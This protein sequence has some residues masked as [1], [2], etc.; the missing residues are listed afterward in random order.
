M[1]RQKKNAS[2]YFCFSS[3]KKLKLEIESIDHNINDLSVNLPAPS[4]HFST[5]VSRGGGKLNGSVSRLIGLHCPVV[6]SRLLFLIGNEVVIKYLDPL[7]ITLFRANL[8][9]RYDM[10]TRQ[11]L[12]KIKS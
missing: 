4:V 1:I 8:I 7:W 11:S 6:M 3:Q 10:C 5:I 9:S 12:Q 2:R